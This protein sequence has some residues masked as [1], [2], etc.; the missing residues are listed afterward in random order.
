MPKTW[1]HPYTEEDR[2]AYVL[3]GDPIAVTYHN[4]ETW[5]ENQR[6]K[7]P[8]AME[9]LIHCLVTHTTNSPTFAKT[10]RR[11]DKDIINDMMPDDLWLNSMYMLEGKYG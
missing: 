10:I 3:C 5:L 9:D 7:P 1:Q 11:N 8:V 4:L 2:L 6:F